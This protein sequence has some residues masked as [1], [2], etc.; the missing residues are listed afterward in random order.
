MG[1]HQP[2]ILSTVHIVRVT[3]SERAVRATILRHRN[4]LCEG[5]DHEVLH[6]TTLLLRHR[7]RQR[8]GLQI[9]TDTHAHGELWQTK[10]RNIEHTIRWQ[11]F[12]AF[13]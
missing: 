11:T 6:I 13:E 9:A 7:P 1:V 8:E 4:Q 10:L 12:D 2:L 5:T 3:R